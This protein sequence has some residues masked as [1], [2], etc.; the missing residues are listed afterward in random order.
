[1]SASGYLVFSFV[2]R[3]MA[4]RDSSMSLV[5]MERFSFALGA[6]REGT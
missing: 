4:E 3:E 1:M 2:Q 6:G 5:S